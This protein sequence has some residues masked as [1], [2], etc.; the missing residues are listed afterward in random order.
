[1][2]IKDN[3]SDFESLTGNEELWAQVLKSSERSAVLVASAA[4]DTHLERILKGYFV[5]NSG[6]SN[7]LV[8]STLN[9]FAAKINICFCL[10]LISSDER[11]D[12]NLLREIRNAFA[13]NL[14]GCDF[15]NP[16]IISL[17][18][19]LTLARKAKA[20]PTKME[21][22]HFFNIGMVA[23]DS[24]ILVRLKSISPVI[25]CQNIKVSGK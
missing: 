8:K 25:E 13:H 16:E 22:K 4:F 11:H 1:V 24:L 21:I 18:S 15:S 23:L 20:D 12:L 10:G 17:V 6:V 19:N 3:K 7:L 9:N 5:Q 2:G 14:F